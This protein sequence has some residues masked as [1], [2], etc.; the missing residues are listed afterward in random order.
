MIDVGANV[1]QYASVLRERGYTGQLLSIEPT[2]EAFEQL[3][4]A[5]SADPR[6]TA[7]RSAAGARA[8]ELEM[9]IAGNSVSSSPLPMLDRHVR[10]EPGSRITGTERVRVERVDVLAA[11]AIGRATAPYLKIDTQGF[12][13]EV[14]DGA[15]EVLQ[16][17]VGLE[18]ELS[19]VELYEGQLLW[20][21]QLDAVEALGFRLAGITGEFFDEATGE[22]LQALASFVRSA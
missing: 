14:L 18:L 9:H 1:G 10:A 5:A 7:V 6:W 4:A 3:A 2:R 21:A 11:D 12:E 13:Q 15:G 20:R 16:R 22:T 17:V 8:G 19:F